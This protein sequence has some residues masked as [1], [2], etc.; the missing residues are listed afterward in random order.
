MNIDKW[1]KENT[2]SLKGKTVAITGS[3]GGIVSNMLK[4]IVNCG[5]N[6][7]FIN[8]NKEKT[9]KQ[10][11]EL[12]KS[13]SNIDIDF[14]QCDLSDFESVKSAVDILKEKNIDILFLGA[15]VYNVPRYLTSLGYDNVF[16][17]NFL[18]HYYMAKQL[19]SQIK[20]KNGK[21]VAIG[22]VAY[23]YSKTNP[24]DLDFS[25]ESKHSKVYGNSK[26]YLMFALQELAKEENVSFSIVHPGITLTEMT[27]HYPK[28]INWLVKIGIKLLFT[29][30]NSACLPLIKG[31]SENTSNF[32][33]IGPSIF[34]IW[35][36][37]SK[38]QIKK[39]PAK[40]SKQIFETAE[41]ICSKLKNNQEIDKK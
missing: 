41:L 24:Q 30:K 28:W 3:N 9:L 39:V 18:S 14:V 29:S 10:I 31:L 37:P 1:I 8:R 34:N 21:I 36:K 20:D 11:E 26:R 25:K 27:N 33:W 17:T 15:G 7:I 2:E 4:M 12:K 5:A 13:N 6:Y 22:S 40:E 19:L 16:Q 35:G 32:E 38:K 23:K